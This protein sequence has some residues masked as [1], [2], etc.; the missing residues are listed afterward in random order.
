MTDVRPR[1]DRNR[2]L[3]VAREIAFPRYPG[4]EG[5]RRAMDLLEARLRQSGLEVSRQDFSYDLRYPF[6]ALRSLL[7]GCGLSVGAAGLLAGGA[8]GWALILLL[9]AIGAAGVFLVWSPWLERLYRGEGPTATANLSGRRRPR[10]PR[11]TLIFLAHHDSKSQN[12]TLPFRALFTLLS[13]G[14]S[15]AL[16]ALLVAGVALGTVPG[17]FWLP[18][19]L[20]VMGAASLW[21]LAS[22]RNGNRS[23]GGVDNSG[24]VGILVELARL[25]PDS[26]P[27]DVELIFLSPGAEEDHMVGAMRWLDE[28]AAEFRSRPT[29]ALNFDGAGIPGRVTLLERYGL[30]RMFSP[31]LSRVARAAARRLGIPAR[32]VL[33][34]PA[35]G[36]DAI[37]FAHRGI[38]CLTF[39]SG[40]LNRATLAVHSANDR[41]ENLDGEALV[42]VARLGIE[43]ARALI[44]EA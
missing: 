41:F 7:A 15:S 30:G 9:G 3:E 18:P 27:K 20:G 28:H 32:G 39:A 14:G 19:A 31:E 42:Q 1:V 44:A 6:R 11:A 17:P 33:L 35:M 13:L 40:S 5:D 12:L 24:S 23:P 34:P 36:V 29:W 10:Q 25:L 4:T 38:D 8:P 43:V 21:T 2:I 37:P 26:L 16:T 22:I